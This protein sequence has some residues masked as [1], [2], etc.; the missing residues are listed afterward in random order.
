M[1]FSLSLD[2]LAGSGVTEDEETTATSG[3]DEA[4]RVGGVI[5]RIIHGTIPFPGCY[6][7][8]SILTAHISLQTFQIQQKCNTK[9]VILTAQ[10][11]LL[12]CIR[13][14][15]I[16]LLYIVVLGF[17]FFPQTSPAPP[18]KLCSKCKEIKSKKVL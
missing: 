9:S 17:P 8:F 4:V 3:S 10:C 2:V 14:N 16:I 12:F 18:Q 13:S 1:S 15:K 7:P 5:E 6:V 11:P